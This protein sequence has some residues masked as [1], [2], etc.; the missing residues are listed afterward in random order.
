MTAI[1]VIHRDEII[2]EIAKGKR[3][4]DICPTYGLSS[5]NSISKVLK[6]DPEY[7]HAIEVGFECRLDE[8]EK[9]IE[10]AIDQV[11][12][13]RARA[14][15]QSVAWRAEREC[16]AKWGSNQQTDSAPMIQIV[17]GADLAAHQSGDCLTIEQK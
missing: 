15:F 12:V 3:L 4:S 8:A 6:S 5:P 16:R 1:A 14:R 10:D 7:R 2:A 9:A 11:D 13:A 17:I